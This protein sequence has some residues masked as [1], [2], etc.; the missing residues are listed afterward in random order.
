MQGLGGELWSFWKLQL[1]LGDS[2]W[3]G[4]QCL[5]PQGKVKFSFGAC[6]FKTWRR[7]GGPDWGKFQPVGSFEMEVTSSGLKK[8]Y[9]AG[10]PGPGWPLGSLHGP[11]GPSPPEPQPCLWGPQPQPCTLDGQV[12]P[13][14][15]HQAGTPT[16]A[17]VPALRPRCSERP[18]P[19]Q[20]GG[21]RRCAAFP[22]CQG[23]RAGSPGEPGSLGLLS[24]DSEEPCSGLSTTGVLCRPQC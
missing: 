3:P 17:Q 16:Q 10:P 4:C 5:N 20:P 21:P 2:S 19:G 6:V 1:S 13:L 8:N 23:Y 7:M 14:A 24:L 11:P 9:Q 15:Q 12:A 18:G 22:V